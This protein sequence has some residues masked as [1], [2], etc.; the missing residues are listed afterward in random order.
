MRFPTYVAL[1]AV[2]FAC[3]HRAPRTNV[4]PYG[5]G[6]YTVSY[7]SIWGLGK[8]RTAAVSDANKFCNFR[9]GAMVP[10]SESSTPDTFELTF[11]CAAEPDLP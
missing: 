3:A 7:S 11:R 5:P 2:A 10:E 9:G 4:Q 1:A 8:A 6:R